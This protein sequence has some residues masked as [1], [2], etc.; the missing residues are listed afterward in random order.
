MIRVGSYRILHKDEL[1]KIDKMAKIARGF[2]EDKLDNIIAGKVFLHKA[3]K[4]KGE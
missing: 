2:T 3:R 1:R 4:K